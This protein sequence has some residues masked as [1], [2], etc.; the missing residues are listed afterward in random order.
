LLTHLEDAKL[1]ENTI[2]IYLHDNGWIQDPA[3][4]TYAA[5]SKRS[6]YDGGTRTP[7]LI[8]WLG[9]VKPTETDALANSIDLAPT[10]LAA[11]G[12]KATND[13]PGINLLDA[14]AVAD[15]T[16]TFGEIFEHNAVDIRVPAKNLQYRWVIDGHWKLIVPNAERIPKGTV[17]FYDLATDP[18]EENNLASQQPERVAA[19]QKKLDAW[20]NGQ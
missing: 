20:W 18:W 10:I 7:V 4:N 19:L 8:R 12:G 14:K 3:K 17:E 5:K 15:R 1:A 6:P 11:T 2:V 9:H 16:A 13:M